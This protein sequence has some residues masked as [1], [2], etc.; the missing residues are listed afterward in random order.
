MCQF[1]RF[2]FIEAVILTDKNMVSIFLF[3]DEHSVDFFLLKYVWFDGL[4]FYTYL[5]LFLSL[6]VTYTQTY[7][8]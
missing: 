3:I 8:A 7:T 4:D 6:P 1:L 2:Y 5:P